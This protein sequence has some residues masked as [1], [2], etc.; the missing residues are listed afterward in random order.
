MRLVDFV[1]WFDS[2][3]NIDMVMRARLVAI[4]RTPYMASS[5]ERHLWLRRPV[6]PSKQL[7]RVPFNNLVR[8]RS[9]DLGHPDQTCSRSDSWY[10]EE[11][12]VE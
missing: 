11:K 8:G 10:S 6:D 3:G 2:V 7:S 9:S 4:S 1:G 5:E 12:V